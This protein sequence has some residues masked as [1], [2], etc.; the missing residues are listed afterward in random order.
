MGMVPFSRICADPQSKLI[1]LSLLHVSARTQRYFFLNLP[2]GACDKSPVRR[3]N[4]PR[5]ELPL[6]PCEIEACVHSAACE[7]RKR[8]LLCWFFVHQAHSAVK[9]LPMHETIQSNVSSIQ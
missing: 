9:S 8:L 4:N 5:F 3:D 7:Q 6:L 1:V 2:P